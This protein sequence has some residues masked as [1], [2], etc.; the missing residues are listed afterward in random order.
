M[1]PEKKIGRRAA[2]SYGRPGTPALKRHA[3]KA[4]RQA[5]KH[6]LATYT[7][8]C[9]ASFEE[10]LGAYGCPNCCGDEGPATRGIPP[11]L[12]RQLAE[13]AREFNRAR[14]AARRQ[15][16]ERVAAAI[17]T[18]P[19]ASRYAC[20]RQAVPIPCVCAF[21]FTC[22]EHGDKHIGSHD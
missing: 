19:S 7:C 2:G 10:A 3:A 13:G 22:P 11:A 18:H 14:E 15:E 1:N 16:R 20:C 8:R 21:A 6:D 17:S 12:E 4:V 9:G 5:A